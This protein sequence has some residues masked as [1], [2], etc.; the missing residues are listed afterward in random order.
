Q[1]AESTLFTDAYK[2]PD[3]AYRATVEALQ[4]FSDNFSKGTE[5]VEKANMHL[6]K[7]QEIINQS[8]KQGIEK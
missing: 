1:Q 3:D 7:A 5:S 8:L 6:E 4:L 2:N